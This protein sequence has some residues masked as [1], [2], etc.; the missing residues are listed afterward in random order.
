MKRYIVATCLVYRS[1]LIILVSALTQGFQVL[2]TERHPSQSS[3]KRLVKKLMNAC[4]FSGLSEHSTSSSSQCL[5]RMRSRWTGTAATGRIES[6]SLAWRGS[7]DRGLK[8]SMK[9][10]VTGALRTRFAVPVVR[11]LPLLLLFAV[12]TEGAVCEKLW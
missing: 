8:P 10:S 11:T 5:S 1:L 12:C 7:R 2:C 3:V 4:E 6:A 9:T